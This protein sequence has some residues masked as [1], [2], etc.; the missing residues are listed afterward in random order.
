MPTPIPIVVLTGYLGAGKTTAVNQLLSLPSIA[1]RRVALIINEFGATGV[2][3]ALVQAKGAPTYEINRGSLF[4]SC[5]Q[6]E[7]ITTLTKIAADGETDL[8]ILEATG[9]AEPADLLPLLAKPGAT[10]E[11]ATRFA[12]QSI[13]ALV[14]AKNFLTV[15]PFLQ[16]ARRQVE[17]ADGIVINKT[18]LVTPAQCDT[19]ASVLHGL[20]PR[21]PQVQVVGAAIP[22][23]FLDSLTHTPVG[24]QPTTSPPLGLYAMTFTPAGP[25]DESALRKLVD[26]LGPSLLRIKGVIRLR[27]D[28]DER[29]RYVEQVGPDL[30][31]HDEPPPARL[32]N[33]SQG[34]LTIIA[35]NL[36]RDELREAM[37]DLV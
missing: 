23:S 4:C 19:L 37:E 20:N 1:A 10:N 25:I 30:L 32:T 29:L 36:P 6:A 35:H 31:I 11:L 17:A 5:S 18:D 28:E 3:G 13:V 22:E 34:Q 7:L 27:R 26:E 15:G 14:D 24:T 16:A 12:I 8:V 2:D 21:S 9:I 33:P